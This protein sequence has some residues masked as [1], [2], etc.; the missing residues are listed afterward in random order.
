MIAEYGTTIGSMLSDL[1]ASFAITFNSIDPIHL[2]AAVAVF[3]V[4]F[5][6]F[7]R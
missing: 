1:A 3:T 4:V 6:L 2:F 7:K 5:V